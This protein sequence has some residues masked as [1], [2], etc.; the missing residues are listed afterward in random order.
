[1]RRRDLTEKRISPQGDGDPF[2]GFNRSFTA[3]V[4]PISASMRRGKSPA[5][6]SG[7]RSSAATMPTGIGCSQPRTVRVLGEPRAPEL[8][9]GAPRP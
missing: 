4:F 3:G 7:G 6:E 2:S 9:F 8:L 5:T 1:V